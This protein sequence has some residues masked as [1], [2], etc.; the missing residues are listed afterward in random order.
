MF[1]YSEMLESSIIFIPFS[2]SVYIALWNEDNISM[3]GLLL[4]SPTVE[5]IHVNDI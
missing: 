3:L 1:N 5:M 4:E 2:I